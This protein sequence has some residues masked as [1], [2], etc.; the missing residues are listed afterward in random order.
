MT[1]ATQVWIGTSWNTNK[2]L[3]A[4]QT[5]VEGQPA[6]GDLRIQRFVIPPFT[7]LKMCA[8]TCEISPMMLKDCDADGLFIGRAAWSVDQYRDILARCAAVL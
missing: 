8:W 3:A 4:S 7:A 5:F 1:R 2:T 6:T